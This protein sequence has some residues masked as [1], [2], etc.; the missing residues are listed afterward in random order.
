M[1]TYRP[2]LALR[3]VLGGVCCLMVVSCTTRSVLRFEKFSGATQK[4]DYASTIA[5][6]KK[7][8][9]LYGN[10][11]RFLYDM[12]IGMLYHY[13]GMYDSSAAYLLKASRTYEDLFTR[14]ATNEGASLLINDN[15]RPY[16]SKPYE[17][18]LL[19][20][21]LQFDFFA[22]GQPDEA[23]VEG[24]SMQLLF[25]EWERK[26]A[27]D[28]H[29]F[30]NGMFH[31][32]TSMIYDEQGQT[33]DA[34][35][36]LYKAVQ[37]FQRGP[38]ELPPAIAAYSSCM[39][40]KNNRVA[41]AEKLNIKTLSVAKKT[42]KG[43]ENEQ[44]EIVV[45]GYAGKGPAL[46]ENEWWGDWVKDGLLVLHHSDHGHEEETMTFPAPG[47]PDREY[48]KAG[49]GQK[50][51]SGT[52]LFIKVALPKVKTFSSQTAYFTVEGD[53][54]ATPVSTYIIEDLDKQAEKQL[55]DAMPS[56]VART[57]VRVATRTIAAQEAKKR[58]E[59][60]S[61]IANLLISIGT[62]VLSSQLEKADTRACFFVPKTIQIARI[63][64]NPGVHTITVTARD[65]SGNALGEKTFP[66]IEVRTHKKQFVFFSC[67]K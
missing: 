55:E 10:N 58:M 53:M 34:M 4:G 63:P 31:Y 36:S 7:Q 51:A 37:A 62:D 41:D 24:R 12:D 13:A 16:R 2:L 30:T 19:H 29:Y 14:S 43:L 56:I 44:T 66:A 17:L 54:V 6:I 38:V 60:D 1:R 57:V 3:L 48:E 25:N 47:L 50:T 28:N 11:N 15:V 35:I 8:P 67:F 22:T 39:L 23:L 59:T 20:Q 18:T 52:T 64:V 21:I 65:Q 45:I 49:K 40:Q 42:D 33:D 26:N 46:V 9:K 5:A 27:K 61:P 32:V